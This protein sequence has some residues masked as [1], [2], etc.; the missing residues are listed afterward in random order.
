LAPIGELAALTTAACWA[1]GSLLFAIVAERAGPFALNCFRITLAMVVLWTAVAVAGLL[2]EAPAPGDPAI[3]WLALSGVIGLSI[4]D[5][6]YFG[7]LRRLGPRVSTLL[8]ALAPP[9]AAALAYVFLHEGLAP[10]ALL[11]MTLTLGGV[12]YVVL[13]RPARAMPAGHRVQGVMLGTLAAA[14]QAT[15][16]VLARHGMGER[17]DPLVATAIRMTAAAV[18][19]WLAALVLSRLDAPLLVWRDPKARVAALGATFLGPLM[20]VWLSLV[21]VKHA[22][23]AVAATL[24]ATTPILILPLVM[25]VKKERIGMRAV[26]GAIVAV[27]GVAL[28]F[29]RRG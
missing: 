16:L 6:G 26:I 24:T 8:G 22:G 11:G 15:G 17:V 4:G 13:D 21:A 25:V 3:G 7:S 12:L 18:T 23:T 9:I 27:A 5:I 10:V 28:L 1:A 20:G 19:T 14:C 29:L 2:R